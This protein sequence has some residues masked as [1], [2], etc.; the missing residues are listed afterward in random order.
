[1]LYPLIDQGLLVNLRLVHGSYNSCMLLLFICHGWLGLSIRQARLQHAALPMQAV[2]R[3]RRLGPI[4]ASMGGLGFMTGL[5]LVLLDRGS[6]LAFP[7]HLLVG[8]VLVTLL[9]ATY[10]VSRK[11]RGA[12]P[13][14]RALHFALGIAILCVYLVEVFLG[15]GILL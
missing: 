9:A 13:A 8:V 4:L 10:L 6:V 7:L 15:L 14:W 11:I 1:M 5:T 12:D 3:H 2:R